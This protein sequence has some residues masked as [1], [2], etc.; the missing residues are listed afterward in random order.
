MVYLTSLLWW[1]LV[2][3]GCLIVWLDCVGLLH[4][5]LCEIEERHHVHPWSEFYLQPPSTLTLPWKFIP[6]PEN[7]ILLEDGH[8]SSP[9]AAAKLLKDRGRGESRT[10]R[11]LRG[12]FPEM[13]FGFLSVECHQKELYG[14]MSRTGRR[15]LAVLSSLRQGQLTASFFTWVMVAPKLRLGGQH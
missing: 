6:G 14:E 15:V 8:V 12:R 9:A 1:D 4:F 7:L 13:D 2:W 11:R 5:R 10:R 3:F